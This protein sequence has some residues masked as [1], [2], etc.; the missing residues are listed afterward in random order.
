MLGLVCVAWP[1]K[2]LEVSL[3]TE[4]SKHPGP[5]AA[6]LQNGGS[7]VPE[8]L[9]TLNPLHRTTWFWTLLLFEMPSFY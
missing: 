2:V 4:F 7:A 9:V 8:N 1:E 6:V 5:S 3:S